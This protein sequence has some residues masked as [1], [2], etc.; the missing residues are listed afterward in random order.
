[1][2]PFETKKRTFGVE[3]V[4]SEYTDRFHQWQ[5]VRDCVEGSDRVKEMGEL[6]LP[7]A[8]G[9]HDQAQKS[10]YEAYKKRAVFVN[11]T[12]QTLEIMHGMIFRRC[13]TIK[14]NDDFFNSGRLDNVD[15]KGSS[16]YQF[17]SNSTYDV[18]QTG[19]GGYL[20]DIPSAPD[21][22]SVADAEKMGVRPFIRYYRAEDIRFWSYD[23]I[24]G[25]ERL[26][27]VVLHENVDTS[28]D[29]FQ[30]VMRD[31]YRVLSFDQDGF[32]YQRV[33]TPVYDKKGKEIEDFSVEVVPVTVNKE[34]I[35]YIPFAMLPYGGPEK[36]MLYDLALL[37]IAHYQSTADYK[38]GVHMTTIPTGYITGHSSPAAS[39]PNEKQDDD[40]TLGGDVFLT[41]ENSDARFGVLTFAGEGLNHAESDID[42]IESQMAGIFLKDIA[43]DKKTSETAESAYVHRAGENA[44]LSTFARNMSIKLTWIIQLYQEWCGY[45]TDEVTVQL[46]YDY[47]TMS[48]DPNVINS[49]ANIAGQGKLPLMCVFW[50]L[51]QQELIDPDFTYDDYT[52]LIDMETSSG[53]NAEEINAAFKERRDKEHRQVKNGR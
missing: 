38:N 25:N 22:I 12:G 23:T 11:F 43:P 52:W 39:N 37:N 7:M 5:L 29:E 34:R 28:G 35:R 27:L 24:G 3:N 10:R 13:P 46:N 16:L 18:M 1:M 33:Y 14:V 8:S 50:I 42:K 36:P 48:L 31:R 26:S 47:E 30:H 15:A 19:F 45:G 20:L 53:F 2:N 6:Y 21:G 40:I 32:Y 51:Q 17:A 9:R 44:K 4:C 41:E 49:I